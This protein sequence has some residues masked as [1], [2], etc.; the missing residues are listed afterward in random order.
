[1]I[2]LKLEIELVDG[3]GRV[4][5]RYRQ[6]ARSLLNQF[7]TML[8]GYFACRYCS[9]VGGGNVTVTD[10]TGTA[11][12]YPNHYST[13]SKYTCYLEWSVNGDVGDVG[14]GIVVGTSDVAN[15]LTT[16]KL[17]AKIAHGSGSGQLY[18]NPMYIGS[19]TNPS[20]G[21]LEFVISRTFSNLSGVTTT[22]K[23]VGI[24]V[25]EIDSGG[26]ARSYLIARD[27]LSTP[28]DVP[29]GYALTVRYKFSITVA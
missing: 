8:R 9:D 25:K 18:Y 26:T 7:I 17:G 10:E 29:P 23:E 15:S 1:M 5:K 14:Q 21:I 20:G 24:L 28:M 13:L 11:T 4:V 16:Y 3:N 19:V 12:T 22:V 6:T 27:V 2:K